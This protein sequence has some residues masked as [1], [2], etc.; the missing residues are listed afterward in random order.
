MVSMNSD[1]KNLFPTPVWKRDSWRELTIDEKDFFTRTQSK[2][3]QVNRGNS[4]TKENYVLNA[5]EMTNLKKDLTSAINSYF[6]EVWQPMYDVKVYITISWI[7]YTEV[8]QFHHEHI[9]ANSIVS[10]VYYIDT[11]DSD[12]VFFNNPQPLWSTLR[13]E[14]R[15]YNDW[16]CGS[17]WLSTPKN[18]LILFPSKLEHSVRESTNPNTRISLSFNTFL[19][20]K[21]SDTLDELYL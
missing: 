15:E 12:K 10:G 8:G 17:S 3:K 11:D 4:H 5:P 16:N 2:E 7:N 9:H 18:S 20:G 21:L 1:W 6:Q 14:P 13:V 19:K